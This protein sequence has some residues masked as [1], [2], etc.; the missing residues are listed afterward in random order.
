[1]E[2]LNKLLLEFAAIFGF[3][4]YDEE[5][6]IYLKKISKP[7]NQICNKNIKL[8]EGGWK[9]KDCET[10]T[11]SIICVQ[12]FEKSK[13]KHKG[14]KVIFEP[15]GS[16]YCDCGDKNAIKEEGFCPDHLGPFKDYENLL[17]FIKS[18]L[19]EKTFTLIDY[20]LEHIFRILVSYIFL[21]ETNSSKYEKETYLMIDK[22]ID[23]I[24]KCYNNN[25]CIFHLITLKL[26]KNYPM[27]TY[28]QCFSYDENTK[29]ITMILE[30]TEHKCGCPF[31]QL[32]INC[33]IKKQNNYNSLE[34]LTLFIQN[35]KIKLIIGM[36]LFHSFAKLHDTE[37]FLQFSGFS[38]Q[39]FDDN[40][41]EV[42]TN[43]NNIKFY[44]N[45]LNE[46]KKQFLKIKKLGQFKILNKFIYNF[47]RTFLHFPA[48]NN[49]KRFISNNKTFETIIDITSEYNNLVNFENK[50]QFNI[51]QREG[52][53]FEKMISEIYPLFIFNL[54]TTLLDYSQKNIVQIKHILKY[55][56]IK[57]S[58]YKDSKKKKTFTFHISLS[59][60]Y[61]IFINRFCI[62][63]SIEK[64]INLYDAF[65]YV[66]KLIP[67][68]YLSL[69]QFLLKELLIFFTFMCSLRYKFFTYFGENMIGYPMNYFTNR[70]FIQCDFVLFKYLISLKEN[71]KLLELNKLL[72]IICIEKSN[73]YFINNIL[74]NKKPFSFFGLFKK[75]SDYDKDLT[76]E[77]NNFYLLNSVLQLILSII[78]DDNFIFELTFECVSNFKMN[79]KDNLLQNLYNIEKDNLKEMLKINVIRN[80]LVND[81]LISISECIDN[82]TE[83]KYYFEDEDIEKIILDNCDKIKSKNNATKFALKK[84]KLI[85]FD[86]DYIPYY[87][88]KGKA[89][90][91][92]MEFKKKEFNLLNTVFAPRLK[93]EKKLGEINIENFIV[94][95]NNYTI[96][97]QLFKKLISDS[98]STKILTL[99][100]YT[101]S[102]Y[103]CVYIKYKNNKISNLFKEDILLA[104]KTT[105]IKDE[106]S[107]SFFELY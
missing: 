68:E 69:N 19:S 21:Y 29:Q 28:H 48:N 90:K 34:F 86:L 59:R 40:L 97:V 37:Y 6:F 10:N 50:L 18:G 15:R 64:N 100:L 23:L 80:I 83:Y 25:L 71:I 101:I 63:L 49:L 77:E 81:N 60:L 82:I 5:L 2:Q 24:Q 78:R 93:I 72:E 38:F 41:F 4:K 16:G 27:L 54:L 20:N 92:L 73:E 70:I 12:C 8:G 39:I 32:L 9:C 56:L 1:M 61:A 11:N 22:I 102:K 107:I 13:E 55:I 17:Q 58:Q 87:E 65:I 7:N 91:Y 74:K 79:Y 104:I 84:A 33:F 31:L 44:N 42:M 51:F 85:Q 57:I 67:K 106:E 14:H 89:M 46:V 95:T 45:F 66:Q 62:S 52:Y 96:F 88:E 47:Y 99:F 35:L 94:Q 53:Q 30:N 36:C 105:K 103:L 3:K 98:K 76:E 43:G 26:I 75:K